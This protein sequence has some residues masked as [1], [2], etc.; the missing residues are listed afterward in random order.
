MKKTYSFSVYK[1]IKKN[2][3][4]K[5]EGKTKAKH[6]SKYIENGRNPMKATEAGI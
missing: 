6:A 3:K 1:S 5:T 2:G 4:E